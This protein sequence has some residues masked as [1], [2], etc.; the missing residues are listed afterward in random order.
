[1]IGNRLVND[2]FGRR[3][4]IVEPPTADDARRMQ[5]EGIRVAWIKGFGM[6]DMPDLSILDGLVDELN[7]I[8]VNLR[9][10]AAAESLPSLK[11]L[12]LQSYAKNPL[13][14]RKFEQLERLSVI[15]RPGAERLFDVTG[16]RSLTIANY[17]FADLT[18]L[19]RLTGLEALTIR[20]SR[21]LVTLAGIEALTALTDVALRD[22]RALVTLEPLG[23]A[24]CRLRKLW[25]QRC[26]K[27]TSIEAVR[28]QPDLEYFD[29]T[30]GGRIDS[31]GPL[32]GLHKLRRFLFYESTVIADGDLSILLRLP[33]LT[34]T[35]FANRRGYSHQNDEI[36]ASRADRR[37]RLT[38]GSRDIA[39]R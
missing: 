10:D 2:D 19:K 23:T 3:I 11:T 29:V 37:G 38:L 30:E 34:D 39:R 20:N 31:L 5:A 36:E 28:G 6:A 4:E 32:A 14:W 15:W 35:A 33:S 8:T 7:V 24:P 16:L 13:D 18:P 9:S 1:M 27:V 17:P 22:D 12:T 21:K 25:V 26:R